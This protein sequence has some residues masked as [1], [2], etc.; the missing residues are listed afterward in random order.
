MPVGTTPQVSPLAV[1]V[2]VPM[3]DA[4][5]FGGLLNMGQ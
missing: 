5:V 1:P 3:T 4:S 2:P